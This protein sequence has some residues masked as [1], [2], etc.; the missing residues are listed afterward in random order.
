MVEYGKMYDDVKKKF[1]GKLE[2]VLDNLPTKLHEDLS[3]SLLEFLK[4]LEYEEVLNAYIC[5]V[6]YH[7]DEDGI[8]YRD[9]EI[10]FYPS[11]DSNDCYKKNIKH[12]YIGSILIVEEKFREFIKE[13]KQTQNFSVKE[14]EM[15]NHD[16]D[17]EQRYLYINFSPVQEK[18][19]K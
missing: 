19:N 12:N 14:Q 8:L 6:G 13:I 1:S 10:C 7:I 15:F 9:D 16:E 2:E 4:Q 17:F 11:L 5:S 3:N 18:I